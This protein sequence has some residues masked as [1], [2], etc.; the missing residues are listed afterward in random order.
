[1][2]ASLTVSRRNREWTRLGKGSFGCVYK[3]EYLGIEVAIKEVLQSTEYDV[4]KYLQREITLMQ[5]ARQCV[6][7]FLSLRLASTDETLLRSPNIVQYLGLC[8]YTVSPRPI[9]FRPN[10]PSLQRSP[11]PSH[12]F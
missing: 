1:M 4:E 10:L 8:L 9:L 11:S 6:L 7:F 2:I 12:R 5:Q 3:G